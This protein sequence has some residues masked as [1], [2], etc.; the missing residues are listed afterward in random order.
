MA[1]GLGTARRDEFLRHL[2]ERQPVVFVGPYEHH[3]NEISWR[4]NLATVVEVG[5][6]G[7]GGL[8][9]AHLESL[10]GR[11]AYRGR[12]LIGSF[13]AASNVTGI[14][15]NT[16]AVSALLHR[17][18]ALSFWDFAAA[19]PALGLQPG[20]GAAIRVLVVV[21]LPGRTVPSVDGHAHAAIAHVNTGQIIVVKLEPDG[22]AD[23]E[24]A[25]VLQPK[26]R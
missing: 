25:A 20:V 15:S 9:L 19:G 18:G 21:Q 14:S 2:A 12:M 26:M 5:L 11:P 6:D 22:P 7:H 13:S 4:Q 10:L 16:R 24:L 1:E 17:H 8:D 3:S 23:L